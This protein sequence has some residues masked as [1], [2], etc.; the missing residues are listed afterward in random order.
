MKTRWCLALIV[1][2]LLVSFLS[3][4]TVA[5]LTGKAAIEPVSFSAGTVLI[6]V[7]AEEE[8]ED[9]VEPGDEEEI[10]ASIESLG[11]KDIVLKL[12]DLKATWK[13]EDGETEDAEEE[14][15][16]TLD[17]KSAD[18]WERDAEDDDNINDYTFYLK[19]E[20]SLGEGQ[21]KDLHLVVEF[22]EDIDDKYT[23]AEFELKGTVDA[24]QVANNAPYH[25]WSTD[26][27]PSPDDEN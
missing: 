11:T 17:E 13:L 20:D 3:G 22:D 4:I 21:E 6:S 2:V 9:P 18:S 24:I 12:D 16:L 25:N 10:E 14:V 8:F 7:E 15:D 5:Y 1:A 26:Y 19:T 27:Y 23:N